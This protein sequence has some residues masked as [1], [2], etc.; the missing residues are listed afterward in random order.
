MADDGADSPVPGMQADTGTDTGTAAGGW[1]ERLRARGVRLPARAVRLWRHRL[2]AS[3]PIPTSDEIA[4]DLRQHPVALVGPAVRTLLGLVAQLRWPAL[5]PTLLFAG[6]VAHWAFRTLHTRLRGSLIAAGVAVVAMLLGSGSGSAGHEVLLAGALLLWAAFD[7]WEWREDRLV[8]TTKRVY[9]VYG[10]LTKHAPSISLTG[11]AYIDTAVN[12]VG[13][14]LHYGLLH[15]DSAAQE[16]APLSRIRNVPDVL[17]VH[18]RILE[19][20]GKAM[21]KFPSTPP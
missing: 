19:L 21:P 8:V 15:L 3:G 20:R 2:P 1:L 17:E 12:P 13:R 5:L 16:D 7:L 11:V 6:A 4:L 14:L 10:L 9:R 18:A